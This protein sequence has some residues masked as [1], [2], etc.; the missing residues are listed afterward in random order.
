M[1]E[2]LHELFHH[3]NHSM[4]EILNAIIKFIF[5]FILFSYYV[6]RVHFLC[7]IIILHFVQLSN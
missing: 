6:M 5:I 3:L 2:P 7:R 1:A 4:N